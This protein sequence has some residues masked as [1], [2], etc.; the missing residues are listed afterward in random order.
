MAQ[1]EAAVV[2]ASALNPIPAVKR[3]GACPKICD[4]ISIVLLS[5]A[6][7]MLPVRARSVEPNVVFL[8][9]ILGS[10]SVSDDL[11]I[12]VTTHGVVVQE[13]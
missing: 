4:S 8:S 9:P 3:L 12:W 7:G 5:S 1:D 11:R 13:A 6:P 10:A 2:D